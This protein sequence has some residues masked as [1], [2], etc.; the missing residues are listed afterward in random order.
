MGSPG[1]AA[2]VLLLESRLQSVL[3]D[4][5]RQAGWEPLCAP[6]V[7]EVEADPEEVRGPLERLCRGDVG[8]VVLQTGVGAARLEQLAHRLGLG[9]AFLQ[10]VRT[11]PLALRGPKPASV[12]GRWGVRAAFAARSPY[13]TRELCLALDPAELAG[14][15][16]FVQH[17]GEPNG[18]LASYLLGRGALPV[19][20]L[21][22]RWALP[23]DPGP[24]RDAVGQVVRGEVD[25]VL[26]TSRAQVLHVFQVAAAMGM[27]D[28]FRRA[29]NHT[30]VGAVG[31]VARRAL[32][33]QGVRVAVEPPQ[34][35]MVPLVQSLRSHLDARRSR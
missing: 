23:E 22:Y 16:V 4:L 15:A 14:R 2:R 24:L 9:E 10:A 33:D 17:H 32:E 34:P 25:A 21:P 3:A 29:L 11:V 18:A 1:S 5:V 6:A 28:A 20:A 27:V 19:D 30:V 26:V 7:R 8:L 13:T 35:K 12:A 31:P